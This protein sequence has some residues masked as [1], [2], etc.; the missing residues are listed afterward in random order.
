MIV[1]RK[2]KVLFCDVDK[3]LI[4]WESGNQWHPH[5]EHIALLR[6][7][8]YQGHGVVVWSAGGYE[9]AERAVYLLGIDDLVDLIVNKPDWYIDDK[10]V[11]EFMPEL[12]RIYLTDGHSKT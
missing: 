11:E 2:N 5:E 12:N 9:W 7:F 1:L 8:K 6:Q 3:T 4:I 10:K